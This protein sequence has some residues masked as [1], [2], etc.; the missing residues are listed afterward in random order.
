MTDQT[1]CAK[2]RIL[3]GNGPVSLEAMHD[4]TDVFINSIHQAFAGKTIDGR[5]LAAAL[6]ASG[7]GVLRDMEMPDPKAFAQDF[8][9]QTNLD[10]IQPFAPTRSS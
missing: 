5:A 3:V 10:W 1:G 6:L 2:A 8:V 7:L 9:A 4:L